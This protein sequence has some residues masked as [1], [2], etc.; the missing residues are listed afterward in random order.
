MKVCPVG[1]EFLADGLTDTQT[2]GQKDRR[3]AA[4]SRL[5]QF[6]ERA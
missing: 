6:C 4:I 2:N 3:D 1:A 5:S